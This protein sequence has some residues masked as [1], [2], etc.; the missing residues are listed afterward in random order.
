MLDALIVGSGTIGVAI[1]TALA[2]HGSKVGLYDN[3]LARQERLLSANFDF[4]EKLLQAVAAPLIK[5]NAIVILRQLKDF[6]AKNYIVCVPTP[7]DAAGQID[8]SYLD[9]SMSELFKI[10]EPGCGIF[11]RS[12][13]GIGMTRAYAQQSIAKGLDFLFA[14][15]PDRS[16]EG[17]SF[18]DQTNVPQLIGAIDSLSHERAH[19]LFSPVSEC[20]ELPSPESAEAAKLFA[21]T[22]RASIFAISN[23]MALV[24]E[25]H[26][27]D[28]KT[29]FS[30]TSKNYPRFTPALPG[31]VGGPCLPKDL[32]ILLSGLPRTYQNFWRGVVDSEAAMLKAII[33]RLDNH[34]AQFNPTLGKIVLAGIAFKGNP[35][36]DDARGSLAI[37][38]HKHISKKWPIYSVVGW[39]P[40]MQSEQLQ[41]CGIVEAESLEVAVKDAILVIVCNNHKIFSTINLD[42]LVNITAAKALFYD[43][44][45]S[46]KA[47]NKLPPNEVLYHALGRGSLD[48][49]G[50]END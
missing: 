1:G 17:H 35:E 30:A 41:E 5:S 42:H 16:I 14:C 11:I 38:L 8:S 40:V 33:D 24:C 12:T 25:N 37:L 7:V 29:I 15:T 27:L 39:D 18:A 43:V 32:K 50:I 26:H 19:D 44:Y 10:A 4:G 21:N 13:V 36:V 28:I 20:I 6:P 31:F 22:W 23:A 45:G 2:S 3:N 49:K 9:V 48:N 34:L 46:C 47:P